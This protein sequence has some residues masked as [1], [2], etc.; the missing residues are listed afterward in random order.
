M[1][2]MIGNSFLNASV[3]GTLKLRS[4]AGHHSCDSCVELPALGSPQQ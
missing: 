4:S 2:A 3:D 1:L